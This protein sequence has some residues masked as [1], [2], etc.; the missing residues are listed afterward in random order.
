MRLFYAYHPYRVN[1]LFTKGSSDYSLAR[2]AQDGIV[3]LG[4]AESKRQSDLVAVEWFAA[5]Y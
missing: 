2:A 1:I 4:F 5:G 3:S